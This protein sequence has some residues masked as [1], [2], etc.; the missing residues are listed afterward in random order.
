MQKEIYKYYQ[1]AEGKIYAY[2]ADGSQ[3]AYIQSGL[4]PITE[5]EADAIRFPPPT[6]AQQA[7]IIRAKRDALL[8]ETD[9]VVIR[10]AEADEAVPAAWK[11]YRQALRDIPEQADFPDA[12]VWPQQP[13]AA[14]AG[15]E[16][17]ETQAAAVPQTA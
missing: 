5:E 11:T 1:D 2:A 4:I 13:Q 6:Q 14:V 12:V 17:T 15:E 10:C 8:K 7:E 3:D 16:M 9:L